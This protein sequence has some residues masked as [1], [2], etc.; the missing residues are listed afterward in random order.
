MYDV[1]D[2][3]KYII[4]YCNINNLEITNLRLNKLLYF[5]QAHFLSA[6]APIFEDDFEAWS[7]GPVIPDIYWKYRLFG[8]GN[9]NLLSN[10]NYDIGSI[11]QEHLLEI[12]SVIDELKN[13]STYDLV[14]ITHSQT[15]WID[16]YEK[17]ANN[18]I[19]KD[20]IQEYFGE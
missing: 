4:N 16:S 20:S 13:I 3:A 7:Y 11:E 8:S 9:I 14:D 15:P 2:I 19:S 6:G 17:F 5:I 1:N 18:I 10:N 12:D